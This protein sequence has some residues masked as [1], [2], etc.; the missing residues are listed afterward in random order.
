MFWYYVLSY[1]FVVGCMIYWA[2]RAFKTEA[3]LAE[4]KMITK[5]LVEQACKVIE[6]SNEI[7]N[8]E[9]SEDGE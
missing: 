2:F 9:V 4:M 6:L 5:A 8:E 3:Q 1:V 7:I